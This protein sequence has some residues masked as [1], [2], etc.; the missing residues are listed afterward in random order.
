MKMGDFD[1]GWN[2]NDF[3]IAWLF[4]NVVA[5]VIISKKDV[6]YTSHTRQMIR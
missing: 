3:I 6:P 2:I 5:M 4:Q 1:C